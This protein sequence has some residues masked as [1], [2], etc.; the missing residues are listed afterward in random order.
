M[1]LFVETQYQCKHTCFEL[2]L[3]CHRTLAQL[4]RINDTSERENH[5]LPFDPYCPVCEPY[6]FTLEPNQQIIL[7]ERLYGGFVRTNIVQ[8]IVDLLEVCPNCSARDELEVVAAK[9]RI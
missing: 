7:D 3:F 6:V 1:C 8:R 9:E 2:Y 4:N 5:A